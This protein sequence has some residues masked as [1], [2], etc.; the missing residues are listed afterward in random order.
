MTYPSKTAYSVPLESLWQNPLP[1]EE[2]SFSKKY[3]FIRSQKLL[4]IRKTE[5]PTRCTHVGEVAPLL[6]NGKQNQRGRGKGN[7]LKSKIFLI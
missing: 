1:E 5:F 2:H 6:T 7:D 3:I 4:S